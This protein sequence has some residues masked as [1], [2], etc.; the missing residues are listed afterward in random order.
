MLNQRRIQEIHEGL[1]ALNQ[2]SHLNKPASPKVFT[3]DR[4]YIN[5][6]H[7][8]NRFI[9]H[10]MISGDSHSGVQTRFAQTGGPRAEW[11]SPSIMLMNLIKRLKSMAMIYILPAPAK[12]L[13]I[14]HRPSGKFELL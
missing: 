9:I 3:G 13:V 4:Q 1:I 11:K 7:T 2:T 10:G 14:L 5:H 12:P 8:V 6:C